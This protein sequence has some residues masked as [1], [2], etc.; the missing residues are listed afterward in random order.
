MKDDRRFAILMNP[1]AASGKPLRLLPEVQRE[2]HTADAPHRVIQTRD[3]AHATHAARDAADKG[4]IVVALGGDGLV[5]TLAGA[6]HGSAALGVLPGGRGNDF[7]RAL[8]IPQDIPGACKVLL[9]GVRKALDLGEANGKSFACIASM[10]YD[11]EANRIANEARLVRGN[12]VYAYA[13]IRALM[14]WKPARFTVRLDGRE[15]RFEGYTVAAANT[16]YYGGGMHMAPGA[17]PS[18]GM[19][20]VIFVEQ[21]SKRRFLANLPKVFKG[22]HVQEDTVKVLRAREVEVTADR[23]FD[24]YADGEPITSMPV[25]IR[26]VRGGL[27]VIAPPAAAS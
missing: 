9:E 1:T 21:V 14:A 16:G 5:G 8:G 20:E 27:S 19:L 22:E 18:D 24:V 15:E 25:S 3:L 7:A 11:S 10:G 17:D 26:L 12:L 2:L 13:A 4:E 6:L 23:P